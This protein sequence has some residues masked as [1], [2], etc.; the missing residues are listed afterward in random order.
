MC[1]LALPSSQTPL[2]MRG[3]LPV[4]GPNASTVCAGG[5]R[6]R[7]A[8]TSPQSRNLSCSPAI[9]PRSSLI[10]EPEFGCAIGRRHWGSGRPGATCTQSIVPYYLLLF[11][12]RDAIDVLPLAILAG[13]GD[14]QGFPIGGVDKSHVGH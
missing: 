2:S 5:P 14:G 13:G 3:H 1:Q 10:Y 6:C 8:V 12:D 4:N 11:V 9:S 7:P